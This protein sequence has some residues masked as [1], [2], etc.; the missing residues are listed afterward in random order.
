ME[1]FFYLGLFPFDIFGSC[2]SQ[3][4]RYACNRA[5]VRSGYIHIYLGTTAA[6]LQYYDSISTIRVP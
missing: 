2:G 1:F 4:F 3:I 5:A 6:S